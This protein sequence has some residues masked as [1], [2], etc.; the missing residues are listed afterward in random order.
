MLLNQLLILYGLEDFIKSFINNDSQELLVYVEDNSEALAY[1]LINLINEL[2]L[3]LNLS[4]NIR[5]A[6]P[7]D[8]SKK[9]NYSNIKWLIISD[10]ECNFYSE[11]IDGLNNEQYIIFHLI[12]GH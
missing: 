12:I 4:L 6:R 10:N 2:L 3:K 5:I 9:N 7:Y 8:L 1:N 11:V